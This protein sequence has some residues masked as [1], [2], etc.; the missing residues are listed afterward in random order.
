MALLATQLSNN[1][2][3][4]GSTYMQ[5]NQYGYIQGAI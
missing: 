5:R 1:V 3:V 4:L 2:P